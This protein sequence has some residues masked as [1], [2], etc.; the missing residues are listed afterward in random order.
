M[1]LEIEDTIKINT[2]QS[3]FNKVFPFLKIEFFSKS[4]ILGKG[5]PKKEMSVNTKKVGECRKSH[6]NGTIYISSDMTVSD[7]EQVFKEQY[8]LNIQVFRKSG[9]IWLETTATD[10]WTLMKQ[11]EAGRELSEL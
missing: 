2:L 10:S 5:S 4:H 8:D 11:N 7:L 3:Q 1:K 6:K 9:K